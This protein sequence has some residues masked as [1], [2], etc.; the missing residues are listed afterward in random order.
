MV[1]AIIGIELLPG[2]NISLCIM[3]FLKSPLVKKHV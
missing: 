2:L 1:A 3:Y